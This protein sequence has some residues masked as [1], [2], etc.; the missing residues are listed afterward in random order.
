MLNLLKVLFQKEINEYSYIPIT[1]EKLQEL[2]GSTIDSILNNATVLVKS[3][4]EQ[5]DLSFFKLEFLNPQTQRYVKYSVVSGVINGTLLP[6]AEGNEIDCKYV[7]PVKRARSLYED[8]IDYG[9]VF[10][11]SINM[12]N[13]TIYSRLTSN[14]NL[15][16]GMGTAELR[17]YAKYISIYYRL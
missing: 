6:L 10:D 1:D 13:N 4:I 9:S 2:L 5:F 14:M 8:C 3:M 15:G 11:I 7:T 12:V 16:G 17:V